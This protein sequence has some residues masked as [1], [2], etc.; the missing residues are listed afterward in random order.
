MTG[1]R[2]SDKAKD[3]LCDNFR[4]DM[5]LGYRE[6]VRHAEKLSSNAKMAGAIEQEIYET[7]NG[8]FVERQAVDYLPVWSKILLG[9][10]MGIKAPGSWSPLVQ[11]RHWCIGDFRWTVCHSLSRSQCRFETR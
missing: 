1:P 10:N 6:G 7:E 9:A 8:S 11:Q 2:R 3:L 5:G 4:S